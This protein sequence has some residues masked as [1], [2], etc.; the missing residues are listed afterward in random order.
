MASFDTDTERP[1]EAMGGEEVPFASLKSNSCAFLSA[2]EVGRYSGIY[3]PT[4][5]SFDALQLL[6][7]RY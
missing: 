2:N 3:E 7:L 6:L 1:V 4:T 5:H